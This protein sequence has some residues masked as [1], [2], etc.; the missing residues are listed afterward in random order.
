MSFFGVKKRHPCPWY[1]SGFGAKVIIDRG[2]LSDGLQIKSNS[3]N[4]FF[5]AF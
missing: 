3:G 2:I 4:L 5:L 1:H